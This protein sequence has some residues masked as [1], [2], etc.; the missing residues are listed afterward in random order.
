MIPGIEYNEQ[1]LTVKYPNGSKIRLFGADNPDSLRGIGL[2]G[3]V[4]DEYSQQ[5]S[6]IFSEIIRPAL[7][8]HAGYAIWIGT[9]KAETTSTASTWA[10]SR[11]RLVRQA[12]ERA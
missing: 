4:F 8:D 1:E 12:P 7:A 10:A 3:V 5:P 6:N 9:R 2:W 11:R